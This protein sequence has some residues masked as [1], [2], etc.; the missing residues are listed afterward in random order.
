MIKSP[1]EIIYVASTRF[2]NETWEQNKTYRTR[3]NFQGCLYSVPKEVA[4]PVIYKS[5]MYILEMNNSKPDKIMGIGIIRNEPL[6][7]Y[8]PIYKEYNYNRYTYGSQKRI[9]RFQLTP[10]ELEGLQIFER[11]VFRGKDHIK[12]GQGITCLPPKKIIGKKKWIYEFLKGL[13]IKYCIANKD[14]I[15]DKYFYNERLFF[16]QMKSVQ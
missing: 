12:R 1:N 3:H 15:E 13:E 5:K 10:E 4:Q 2:N 6:I 14:D 9:D 7:K 16:T 8:Y 11:L